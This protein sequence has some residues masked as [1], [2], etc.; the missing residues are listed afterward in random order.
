MKIR[1]EISALAVFSKEAKKLVPGGSVGVMFRGHP[2]RFAGIPI[3]VA[4]NLG[5]IIVTFEDSAIG[6]AG[7]EKAY[8]G[9]VIKPLKPGIL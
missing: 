7:A 3:G 4:E 1:L 5:E 2:T 6:N 8:L 9:V